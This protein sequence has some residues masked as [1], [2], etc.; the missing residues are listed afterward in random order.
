MG[1]HNAATT[2]TL[3]DQQ[4]SGNLA[5]NELYVNW[6]HEFGVLTVGR[7]PMHFGLGIQFNGGFGAFD[8]WLE[9]RDLM[10]YK[11]VTGAF[12]FM[13]AFGKSFEGDLG[14]TDDINDYILQVNYENPD[15]N[16]A[17]GFLYQARRSGG[18]NSNDTPTPPLSSTGVQWGLQSELL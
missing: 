7:A 6:V 15:T 18:G 17:V 2:N 1:G 8:H 3:G 11:I 13:P 16:L 4:A 5:V 12:T 10:A 9:N 14:Q